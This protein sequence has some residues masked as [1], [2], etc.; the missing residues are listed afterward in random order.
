MA[1]RLADVEAPLGRARELGFLGPGPVA[2]QVDHARGFARAWASVSP[3]SSPSSVAD[4]GS[5]GGLP[6]LVLAAEW[7]QT[8]LVR[9]ESMTRRASFLDSVRQEL[10]WPNLAVDRRRAE[11][12]G[13]DPAYRGAF[14]LVVARGLGP[15]PVTAE[16]G[17]PLL[18]PGARLIVSE[19]P[20]ERGERWPPAN[21][22]DLGLTVERYVEDA[23]HYVV[24][25]QSEPTPER[26]P[27]RAGQ[28]A[29]RPLW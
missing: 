5:G 20:E 16:C 12:L 2:D 14:D 29:K 15:P 17:A 28:P 19:P 24:L 13:R 8:R 21:L 1:G 22:A 4:L 25:R 10:A 18:R 11:A 9:V 26:Y 7:P 27:R 6:G 3:G 23:A